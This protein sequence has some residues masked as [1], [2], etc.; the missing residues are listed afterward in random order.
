MSD[1]RC[2]HCANYAPAVDSELGDHL[3]RR[4]NVLTIGAV[5][6]LVTALV[7]LLVWMLSIV[8][9][10]QRVANDTAATAH[11]TDAEVLRIVKDDQARIASLTAD[12]ATLNARGLANGSR[13]ADLQRQLETVHD[14]LN[15]VLAAATPAQRQVI[16]QEYSTTTTTQAPTKTTTT[17]QAPTTT[18]TR[19][20]ISVGAQRR[21]GPHAYAGPKGAQ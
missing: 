17:T 11:H 13:E 7:V 3:A 20:L 14:E 6:A 15:A 2:D 21:N 5:L 12:I 19:P 18:T 16:V 8:L 10:V 9:G 4:A 1:A